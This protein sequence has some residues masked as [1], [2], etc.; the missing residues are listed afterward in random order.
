MVPDDRGFDGAA[1]WRELSSSKLG[2]AFRRQVP[3]G[4]RYIGDFVAPTA[5]L[6]IEVDGAAHV[7]RSTAAAVR[8]DRVLHRLGY[9]VLRLE[10]SL[11]M[12]QPS[13]AP[14]RVREA[15]SRG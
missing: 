12:R 2:V 6:L 4:G 3:L 10:A 1:L 11:V 5:R 7:G 9:R 14:A 8:R 15:L 13:V